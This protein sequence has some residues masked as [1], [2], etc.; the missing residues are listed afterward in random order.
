MEH[1]RPI[2]WANVTNSIQLVLCEAADI[3]F[4]FFSLLVLQAAKCQITGDNVWI[5]GMSGPEKSL[6]ALL[7]AIGVAKD[8]LNVILNEV[9]KCMWRMKF[10]ECLSITRLQLP[11]SSNMNGRKKYETEKS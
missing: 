11:A 9:F 1:S 6:Q 2:L 4:P 8:E 10:G 3:S 5:F 7:I